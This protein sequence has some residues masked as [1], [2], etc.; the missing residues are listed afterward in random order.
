MLPRSVSWNCRLHYM[1]IVSPRACSSLPPAACT[2][3]S[4]AVRLPRGGTRLSCDGETP[5]LEGLHGGRLLN[6]SGSRA[7]SSGM[8]EAVRAPTSA[9]VFALVATG[10][11]SIV[12]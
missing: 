9:R 3:A 10:G 2:R 4:L 8:K 5:V 12:V 11:V 7:L 1:A 6:R